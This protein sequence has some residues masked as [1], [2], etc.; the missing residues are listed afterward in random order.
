MPFPFRAKLNLKTLTCTE[1]LNQKFSLVSCF[2]ITAELPRRLIPIPLALPRN[3]A[4]NQAYTQRHSPLKHRTKVKQKTLDIYLD[5]L[6]NKKV[7]CTRADFY[8][9]ERS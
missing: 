7:S 1:N 2:N 3:K 5:T 6:Y 8:N 9:I 4:K